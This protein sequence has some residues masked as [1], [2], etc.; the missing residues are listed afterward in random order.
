M[1][2]CKYTLYL[3]FCFYIRKNHPKEEPIKSITI[4]QNQINMGLLDAVLG[5]VSEI[6]PKSL[7]QEYGE[8]LCNGEQI[9]RVF[10]LIRDKWVFTNK[11][12]IIQD[13]QG[14]TG[15]KREYHSI[16]YG[17]ITQFSIETCGTIDMDSEM[18]IWIKGMASPIEQKFGTK[19][20]IKEVQRILAGYI[21]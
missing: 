16:P 2:K 1:K 11:R 9:E 12:L 21:L 5:N 15:K 17:S 20:N 8:L 4:N 10:V 14:V 3:F 7:Q 6:D 19:V 13:T 18:K